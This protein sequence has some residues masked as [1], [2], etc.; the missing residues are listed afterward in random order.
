MSLRA[1]RILV[2]AGMT[3]TL[4]MLLVMVTVRTR[5][6]AAV[7][8]VSS[9]SFSPDFSLPDVRGEEVRLNDY[10]GDVVLLNFWATWCE[11]C[12]R[13]IPWLTEFH[14]AFSRRGFTVLGIS[15]DRGGRQVVADF[16]RHHALNYRVLLGDT[17]LPVK[18]GSIDV[19]P[20]SIL[21]DRH[22]RI[23]TLKTGIIDREQFRIQIEL[24]LKE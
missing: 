17:E 13:E 5:G 3:T 21:I 19:L 2:V 8:P 12:Q 22:G 1:G 6:S 14:Q 20:M 4:A 10:L 16:V 18:F 9:R 11:P 23:A 24:L 15:M 7:S